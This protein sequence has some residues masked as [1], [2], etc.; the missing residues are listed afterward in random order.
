MADVDTEKSFYDEFIAQGKSK[1][2]HISSIIFIKF[3]EKKFL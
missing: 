1:T 3:D 2:F